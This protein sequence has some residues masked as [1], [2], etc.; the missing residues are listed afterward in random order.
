MSKKT[1]V[2]LYNG[3]EAE[4]SSDQDAEKCEG[5][6]CHKKKKRKVSPASAAKNYGCG[7][8]NAEFLC[9]IYAANHFLIGQVPAA[10]MQTRPFSR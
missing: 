7:Q 9:E 8:K 10:K 6:S 1:L 4:D 5:Q 2:M 3:G